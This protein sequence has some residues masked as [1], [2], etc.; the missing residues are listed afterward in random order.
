MNKVEKVS[1][2]KCAFSLEAEAYTTVKEYLDSL[3][4]W[5][6]DREGGKE[7]MEGIEERMA[8]L[9]MDKTDGG[10][11]VVTKHDVDEILEILGRPETIEED[12]ESGAGSSQYKFEGKKKFY[13]DPTDRVIGG[14][15]S[16]MAA[17]FNTDALLMRLIFVLA[18][19]LPLMTW[20]EGTLIAPVVYL[21]M[22]IATPKADT[23]RKQCELHGRNLSINDLEQS[24]A[25]GAS[26]VPGRNNSSKTTWRICAIV[27][28]AFLLLTGISGLLAGGFAAFGSSAF[29]HVNSQ[30]FV[31]AMDEFFG[32]FGG[33]YQSFIGSIGP[34]VKLL[35][36]IFGSLTCFLP[37]IGCIYA[38][39][40]LIFDLKSPS[41]RPGLVLFLLWLLA[42]VGLF[43]MLVIASCS[44]VSWSSGPGF[45]ALI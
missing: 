9:L 27:I 34:T 21:I 36:I 38:G 15:C 12:S 8:E 4:A 29:L 37:F 43:I 44:F 35:L 40:Y 31:E 14:V 18:T 45:T 30:L 22:W 23:L 20:E 3:T 7:I 10:N 2:G 17:Y 42:I 6:R 11:N 24:Y 5:Y 32:E 13:R 28:G 25:T 19:C 33:S 26:P 16:G 41:W 39:L 1:I